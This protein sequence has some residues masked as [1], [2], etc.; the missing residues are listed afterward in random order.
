MSNDAIRWPMSAS[1]TVIDRIF[2]LA[3]SFRSLAFQMFEFENLG[4][5]YDIRND[6][7]R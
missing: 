7:Y 6:D 1:M 2:V 5:V 4:Q 3:L